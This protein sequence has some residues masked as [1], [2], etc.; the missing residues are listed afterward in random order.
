MW[1]DGG[2]EDAEW[3]HWPLKRYLKGHS[4]AFFFFFYTLHED[5]QR[6]GREK[7]DTRLW[8]Q[9]YNIYFGFWGS[10]VKEMMI[11]S[12]LPRLQLEANLLQKVCKENS[13]NQVC[14]GR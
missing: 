12:R 5:H 13:Q 14:S 1:D 8:K 10:F 4:G 11:S 6:G 2:E 9:L 7:D 3:L